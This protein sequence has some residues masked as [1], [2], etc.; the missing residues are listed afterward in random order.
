VEEADAVDRRSEPPALSGVGSGFPGYIPNELLQASDLPTADADTQPWDCP[1]HA[2]RPYHAFALTFPGYQA[3][4]DDW[5]DIA[6]DA[7]QRW[8]TCGELPATL[9]EL[10]GLLFVEQRAYHWTAGDFDEQRPFATAYIRALVDAIRAIVSNDD[11]RR[12]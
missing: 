10:R 6:L 8:Q 1:Y 2:D 5:L 11:V 7:R 4:G 3:L 12:A 9:T